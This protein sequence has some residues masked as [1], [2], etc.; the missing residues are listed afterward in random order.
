MPAN[1]KYEAILAKHLAMNAATWAQLEKHGVMPN[2]E[3]QLDFTYYAPSKE[4][5]ERLQGVLS[6]YEYSVVLKKTGVLPWSKWLISGRTSKTTLTLEKLNQWVLW[7]VTAGKEFDSEFD[8]WG[9]E[10]P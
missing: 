8:G 7:M 3:L 6:E 9:A 2:T 4:K 5:A 10:L 1:D